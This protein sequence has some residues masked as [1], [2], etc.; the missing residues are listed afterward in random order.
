M[1]EFASGK[2]TWLTLLNRDLMNAKATSPITGS[3]EVELIHLID[4]PTLILA[5]R[6]TFQIDISYLVAPLQE[7]ALYKCKTSGYRF[8]YPHN[9]VGDSAFYHCLEANDWY[10]MPRKWEFNESINHVSGGA[11]L[12][13]GSAKGDFLAAVRQTYPDSKLVGL[14]LNQ[15]AAK[16][17]NRRG[18]D[19]RIELSSDHVKSN[20][21]QYDVVASF[22]VLEHIRDPIEFLKDSIEMLK[23]GGKLIIAVPDN[24]TR[25]YPSLFVMTDH[26]LN[27]PPHHQGLWD[28]PSLSYL[29]KVLPLRLV[30]IAI[31]PSTAS[32]HR[33][34]YRGLIKKDLMLRFG[35]V[36]GYIIYLIGRPFY[37]QALRYFDKYL[38]AHSVLAIFEKTA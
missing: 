35:Q 33:N 29:T 28:I 34:G 2:M 5:Y 26:I 3:H 15:E 17:A 12:E 21:E 6:T 18:F 20:R 10:Y 38:P 9:V 11:I 7:M 24:S 37:K 1:T 4:L 36:L 30:Y 31:E 27:M 14:E 16:E 8:Y 22:Q 19:V 23:P 32:H 25:A 13:I